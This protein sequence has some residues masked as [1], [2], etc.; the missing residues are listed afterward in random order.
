MV[1]G[2]V[3]FID[4]IDQYTSVADPGFPRR[5]GKEMRQFGGKPIYLVRFLLEIARQ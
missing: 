3:R 1:W 2:L 4:H 5:S